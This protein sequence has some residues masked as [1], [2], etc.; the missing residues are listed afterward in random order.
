[1]THW[2]TLSETPS[3]EMILWRRG[4]VL[5]SGLLIGGGL[6]MLVWGLA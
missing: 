5:V 3:R 6:A 1:M 2:R 4:V